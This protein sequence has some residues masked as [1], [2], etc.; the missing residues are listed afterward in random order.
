MKLNN[1]VFLIVI[2][3]PVGVVSPVAS[4]DAKNKHKKAIGNR[5]SNLNFR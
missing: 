1:D 2:Y 4:E 5:K 3:C